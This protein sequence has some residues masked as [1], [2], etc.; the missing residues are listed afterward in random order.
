MK[1]LTVSTPPYL[2][3]EMSQFWKMK[4]LQLLMIG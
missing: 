2:K 3:V 1:L 4:T